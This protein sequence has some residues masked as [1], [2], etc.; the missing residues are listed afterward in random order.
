MEVD[1]FDKVLQDQ[2]FANMQEF[3]PELLDLYRNNIG[4]AMAKLRES[5]QAED[6]KGVCK[7]AHNLKGMSSVVCA[8]AVQNLSAE[9]E[10]AAQKKDLDA[11]LALL[12]KLE[13]RVERTLAYL[14]ATLPG[15]V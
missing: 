5:F 3:L 4:P 15:S 2:R 9:L 8:Q 14:N 1:L 13:D 12:A 7:A 6:L 10:S 11:S